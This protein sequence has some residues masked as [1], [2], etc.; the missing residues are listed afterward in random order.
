MTTQDIWDLADGCIE[1]GF[2]PRLSGQRFVLGL[3]VPGTGRAII[4]RAEIS[5]RL[6]TP[7]R[8]W[9]MSGR[10]CFLLGDSHALPGDLDCG[11]R[12]PYTS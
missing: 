12:P 4:H 10:R 11:V 5:F 9:L 8:V 2:F 6:D 3:E 1:R 7:C